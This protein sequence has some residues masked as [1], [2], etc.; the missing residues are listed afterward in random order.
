MRLEILGQLKNSMSW[1]GIEPATFRLV[2]QC[3]HQPRYSVR[4]VQSKQNL[5]KTK[6]SYDASL[7]S[8]KVVY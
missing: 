6:V 7:I 5:F 2:A 1:S 3:L 4:L 8:L